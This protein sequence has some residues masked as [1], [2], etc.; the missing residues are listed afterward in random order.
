MRRGAILT[1]RAY[2]SV[3]V[4][5]LRLVKSQS[6]RELYGV[7]FQLTIHNVS[8]VKVQ[9]LGRKWTIREGDGTLRIIEGEHVFGVDPLLEPGS[10]FGYSGCLRFEKR[11]KA[12]ELRF[13]GYDERASWF[14][15]PP[16]VFPMQNLTLTQEK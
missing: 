2:L 7:V 16:C 10:I 4:P 5:F 11:P 9:L 3:H 6:G 13:F 15:S 14:I 8:T 12:M 1:E